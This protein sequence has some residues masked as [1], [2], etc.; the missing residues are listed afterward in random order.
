ME[1]EHHILLVTDSIN[2]YNSINSCWQKSKLLNKKYKLSWLSEYSQWEQEIV[3]QRYSICLVDRHFLSK[4]KEQ[5]KIYKLP[6]IALTEDYETGLNTIEA[7]ANDYWNLTN[8]HPCE[9]ERSLRLILNNNSSFSGINT[10]REP[11]FYEEFL[12]HCVD[13][14]FTINILSDGTLVYGSVNSAYEKL[15]GIP[16]EKIIGKKNY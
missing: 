9:I 13:G 15:T 3:K 1:T 14:L 7:G 6:L 11:N 16:K 4:I 8:L 2:T 10:W 12:R 5:D